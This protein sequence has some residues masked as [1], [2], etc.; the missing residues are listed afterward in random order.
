MDRFQNSAALATYRKG[1]ADSYQLHQERPPSVDQS[2]RGAESPGRSARALA[3]EGCNR[4]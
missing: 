1:H 3:R 4:G 2:F